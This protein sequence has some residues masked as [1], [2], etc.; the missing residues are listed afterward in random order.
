MKKHITLSLMFLLA[1]VFILPIKAQD[2]SLIKAIEQG[3][4]KEVKTI[5]KTNNSKDNKWRENSLLLAVVGNQ[6]KIAKFLLSQGEDP[7]AIFR[8]ITSPLLAAIEHG[9]IKM[10]KLLLANGAN[11]NAKDYDGFTPLDF[12]ERFYP[13]T[14]EIKQLLISRGAKSAKDLE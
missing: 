11:V 4:L 5:F 9:N 10:V 2:N 7:N 6:Y 12:A 1:F 8:G 13:E 14:D 3:N